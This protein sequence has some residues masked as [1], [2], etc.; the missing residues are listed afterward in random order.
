MRGKKQHADADRTARFGK[1][2]VLCFLHVWT[3]PP[4]E[5]GKTHGNTNPTPEHVAEVAA[6]RA[7]ELKDVLRRGGGP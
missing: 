7:E 5:Q 4:A 6:A 3:D 2:E 1:V